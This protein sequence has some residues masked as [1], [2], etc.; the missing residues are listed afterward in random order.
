MRL[1]LF[2]KVSRLVVRRSVASEICHAG[3]VR[4]N[5]NI[6]KPSRELKIGDTLL[7]RRRGQILQ[8]RIMQIPTGNVPKAQAATLYEILGTTSYSEIQTLLTVPFEPQ[9]Q[10]EEEKE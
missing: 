6:A 1:D 9:E 4:V 5:D 10:L 8:V 7:I 3:A 2:L